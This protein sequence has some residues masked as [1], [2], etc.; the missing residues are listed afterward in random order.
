MKVISISPGESTENFID[1]SFKLHEGNPKWIP[2]FRE[3]LKKFLSTRNPLF[4]KIRA[5]YF[6]V[7]RDGEICGRVAASFDPTLNTEEPTAYFGF[8]DCIADVKVAKLLWDA[9]GA[10]AREQGASVV[11]GPVDFE[12][13]YSVGM[14]EKGH[15]EPICTG[16]SWNPPYYN[17][18]ATHYQMKLKNRCFAYRGSLLESVSPKLTQAYERSLTDGIQFRMTSQNTL[19]TD[20]LM[21]LDMYNR[22]WEGERH[23]LWSHWGEAEALDFYESCKDLI[24]PRLFFV[25]QDGGRP[26]GLAFALPNYAKPF[27]VFRGDLS[28]A[29]DFKFSEEIQGRF[30]LNEI[31]TLLMIVEPQYQGRGVASALNKCLLFSAKSAGYQ[32]INRGI[33]WDHITSSKR[34][35]ESSGAREFKQYA[36]YYYQVKV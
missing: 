3:S 14:L 19:R 11:M 35:A 1:F 27:Q 30:G 32:V 24:D 20:V 12:T 17:D 36:L 16:L 4:E 9:V 34:Q 22:V 15:D 21:M 8:F 13:R 33:I 26:I 28:R 6:L 29:V 7:V 23:F 18:L 2:P 25:A 5:Q 10:W 31:K